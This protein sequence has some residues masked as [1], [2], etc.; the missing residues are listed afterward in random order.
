MGRGK[1]ACTIAQMMATGPPII[2]AQKGKVM[3]PVAETG[4]YIYNTKQIIRWHA[5]LHASGDE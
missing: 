1:A 4:L 2:T 3:D 5:A